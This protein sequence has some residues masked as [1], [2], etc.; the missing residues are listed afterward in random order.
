MNLKKFKDLKQDK[1]K[2]NI[3][4]SIFLLIFLIG[5]ILLYKS[6]A[7]YKEEKSFNVLQGVVPDFLKEERLNEFI[8]NKSS[9]DTTIEKL[10]HSATEQTPELTDYR[11]VGAN[12]NNYVYFGC[13]DNCTENNLYRIIGVIPTQSSESGEYINRV[14]LIKADYYTEEESGLLTSSWG[15]FLA[16]GGTGKGYYWDR[17]V[18]NKWEDSTLKSKVLNEVYWNSLRE[19][20]SYVESAKWYLGA[21]IHSNYTTYT[22]D[23]FYNIERSNITGYSKGA[24]SFVANIGL[25]YPSDYAYS[26]GKTNN[27]LSVYNDA[28]NYINNAWLYNLENKYYEWILNPEQG[29]SYVYA[30]SLTKDGYLQSSVIYYQYAAYIYGIRPTFYLKENVLKTGG[31]G[32]IA[33]PYRISMEDEYLNEYLI[34]KSNTDTTIEK[35]EH[36]ATEQTPELTDYRY[37]GA[38]PN[39]YVY[40]GCSDNC[41][42]DN[43]YRI[44]GVIPTQSSESGEY[45]NRVKLIKANYYGENI[46]N[47]YKI[48]ED[49]T[50][51]TRSGKGYRWNSSNYNQW[52]TVN[53]QTTVLNNIYYNSLADFK[54][55]IDP[56]V[57]YLGAPNYAKASSYSTNQLYSIE[58]GNTSGYSGGKTRFVGNIGLMSLSD[59]GYAL[60]GQ[61]A[62]NTINSNFNKYSNSS[63]LYNLENKYYEWTIVPESVA[64]SGRAWY[65]NSN[66]AINS[67]PMSNNSNCYEIRPTF[68]LRSDVTYLYGEGSIENPYRI[69]I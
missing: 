69:G 7:L 36:S 17:K 22:P 43:L 48:P 32:T 10:E 42:E 62:E 14:K 35:L 59:Y 56:A 9:K 18:N 16:G 31:N 60:G 27:E 1:S 15:D 20:Q 2:R 46:S 61:Y 38:N 67:N 34:N 65:I 54:N 68:Y 66:G 11:Y 55:Y 6:Y 21:P 58:R 64:T 24:I 23:Q 25:M 45:I 39:N 19:Y 37:V 53:L 28:N 63:W 4:I 50:V 8:I 12:P 30:W 5:G 3:A 57:W 40:F 52:A 41:T 51:T 49:G 26:V 47:L 44:I 29:H 33:N 13:S